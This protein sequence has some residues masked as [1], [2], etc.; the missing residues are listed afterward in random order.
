MYITTKYIYLCIIFTIRKRIVFL[1]VL[2][3]H[4]EKEHK[5]L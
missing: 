4:H 3:L 2:L 5:A 1:I